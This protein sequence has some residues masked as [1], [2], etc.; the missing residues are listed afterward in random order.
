M[1]DFDKEYVRKES[2]CYKHDAMKI[3]YGR[4]DLL[5]LWVAD[6]EFAT[7]PEIIKAIQ[8][9]IEHPIFGYNFKGF[10]YFK[11]F[12]KYVAKRHNWETQSS[13]MLMSPGIVPAINFLIKI[14][15]NEGDSVVIQQPVYAPFGEAV[16][17]HSR[18]LLINELVEKDGE[19][20]FDYEDLE[21][22]LKVAKVLIFCSPHNPIGRVW[23][24]EEL[25]KIGRLCKKH[26]VLIFSDEIHNDLIYKGYKHTPIAMLEDFGD[27]TVTLM[28]PSKTF[29]IAGLQSS[30]LITQ[31]EEILKKIKHYFF[32]IHVYGSNSIGNVAFDAAYTDGEAWLEAL[33]EYLEANA[34]YLVG[35]IAKMPYLKLRKPEGTFLAW[36]DFKDTG[37]SLPEIKE[38][39]I[40]KADLALNDGISFGQNGSGFMRLNF[41]CPRAVL[42]KAMDNLESALK[43]I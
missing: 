30:V 25:L 33:L 12:I 35:R 8:K 37:L 18:N 36:V 10:D 9:R 28:A 42:V 5:P 29:N 41:G 40:N 13:W 14:F 19:Y 32:A 34:D 27:L 11:N 31:N 20:T 38:L 22:K 6:M 7:A 26:N 1:Y 4:D 3:V 21:A 43:D 16:T 15:T 39:C 24:E 23:R 17:S 2:Q